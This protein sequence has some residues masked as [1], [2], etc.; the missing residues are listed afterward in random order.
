MKEFNLYYQINN[1]D[2][3]YHLGGIKNNPYFLIESEIR[4]SDDIT[5]EFIND[6]LVNDG[7]NLAE[8]SKYLIEI[9][10]NDKT[11]LYSLMDNGNIE[12]IKNF[13]N[14]YMHLILLELEDGETSP[15]FDY[16]ID[17][18]LTIFD[19]ELDNL[20]KDLEKISNDIK[21]EKSYKEKKAFYNLYKNFEKKNIIKNSS[22]SK[23]P[24]LISKSSLKKK[25]KSEN[26]R[27][28]TNLENVDTNENDQPL[29]RQTITTNKNK[30]KEAKE[31]NLLYLYS[32]P[33]MDL[34]CEKIY[35]NDDYFN[36]M[37]S[38]YDEFKNS[39]VTASLNFE[40]IVHIFNNQELNNPNIIHIKINS[41]INNKKLYIDLDDFGLLKYYKCEEL[42]ELF[43]Q[44]FD[45]QQIKL[46][47]LSTQNIDEMKEVFNNIGIKTIIYIKSEIKYP[48][49]NIQEEKFIKKLYE[50]ML[51]KGY[52]I[53]ESFKE[54]IKEKGKLIIDA[55]LISSSKEENDDFIYTYI[56]ENNQNNIKINKNC[57]LN[58]D[59]V[60]YNY[61][62]IIGRNFELKNCI[63]QLKIYNNVCVCG[64]PGAGKKSFIQ[65]VGKY[66]FERKE[67]EYVH[68]LEIHSSK[69]DEDVILMNKKQ[70][71]LSKLNINDDNNQLENT[72]LLIINFNYIITN[73][74]DVINL[75]SLINKI[76]D[77]YINC[78]YSFTISEKLQFN[79]VK[80]KLKKTPMIVLDKLEDEKKMN[81][82]NCIAY[83]LKKKSFK[84]KK[85]K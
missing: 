70:E 68:Y 59:F 26:I 51:N 1:S 40:P 30:I 12:K 74:N 29:G 31:I 72:I 65:L 27:L 85:K 15:S 83:N 20:N 67:F 34:K 55:E 66:T 17:E 73:K 48:E 2:E 39:G 3:I 77:K 82:Y 46:L 79:E 75:E 32:N 45:L 23:N 41:T 76:G 14:I 64:Y 13:N 22:P 78:L 6:L 28:I 21:K 81:I 43:G 35:Q 33:L 57:C 62:R 50:Y 61:K 49:P 10:E 52:P 58:L 47:I 80:Q 11:K 71:I 69:K 84:K 54:S 5:I 25:G 53:K 44:L 16:I 42:K 9:K 37:V 56:N 7:V 60:K 36:E 38:I 4:N 18:E 19:K 8:I 24:N 63:Q